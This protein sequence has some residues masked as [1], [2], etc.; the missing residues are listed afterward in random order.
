[1]RLVRPY[2]KISGAVTTRESAAATILPAV[3]AKSE[4]PER[5]LIAAWLSLNW[6]TAAG[7]SESVLRL[8]GHVVRR[9]GRDAV[10]L[11]P[12]ASGS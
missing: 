2:S 10:Q 3:S 9:T 12:T 1:M 8:L 6:G 4:S 5:L 11:R 7:P